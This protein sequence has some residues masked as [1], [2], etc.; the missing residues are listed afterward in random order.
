M[1]KKKMIEETNK[2]IEENQINDILKRI[3]DNNKSNTFTDNGDWVYL[4]Q[5]YHLLGDLL[6]KLS[7]YEKGTY[8][9]KLSKN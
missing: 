3:N 8:K 7:R 5:D 4:W 2:F 6:Q 1:S 9:K